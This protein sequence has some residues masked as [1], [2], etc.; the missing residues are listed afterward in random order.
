MIRHKSLD[1]RLVREVSFPATSITRVALESVHG[2]RY[3]TFLRRSIASAHGDT[4][5]TSYPLTGQAAQAVDGRDWNGVCVCSS[6]SVEADR[7]ASVLDLN[8]P[9]LKMT[10]K[11]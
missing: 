1:V 8:S 9:L 7:A 2:A 4:R 6:S 5:P 11:G 3:P 10:I